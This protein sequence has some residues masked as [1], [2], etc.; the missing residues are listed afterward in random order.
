MYCCA[1]V[2]YD[3]LLACIICLLLIVMLICFDGGGVPWEA[4]EEGAAVGRGSLFIGR[5]NTWETDN[6]HVTTIISK[7]M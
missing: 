7:W 6:H 4:G 3:S 5:S 1:T 2:A